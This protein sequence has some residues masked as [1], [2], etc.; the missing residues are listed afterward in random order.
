MFRKIFHRDE[1]GQPAVIVYQRKLLYA[2]TAQQGLRLKQRCAG[3]RGDEALARH[4]VGDRP[5]LIARFQKADVAIGDESDEASVGDN[6]RNATEAE[7]RHQRF[8]LRHGGRRTNGDRIG[9]H[10]RLAALDSPDF[11]RLI[12]GIEIA[13]DHPDTS[14]SG[15]RDG[16]A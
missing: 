6:H 9:N 12:I 5:M 4:K 14:L 13:M 7:S 15:Q 8:S 16:H 3:G 11:G 2:M 10:P 1:T